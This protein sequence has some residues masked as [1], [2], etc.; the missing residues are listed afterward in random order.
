M[1][2]EARKRGLPGELPVMAGLVESGLKNL[3]HGDADSL[4]L[5]Q[6][7]VSIW[8]RGEYAGFAKDPKLQL[9][10]FL[11]HAETV[12]A[13]RVARGL[14]IDRGSY[15]EWVADV[16]RPAE[17][18]RGRYQERLDEARQLLAAASERPAG[19]ASSAGGA[20]PKALL[21]VAEARKQLGTPYRWGGESKATGFDCSGLMQWAYARAGI[22]L[23]RVADQQ[24][25]AGG[26][27]AVDR[28]HLEPGDLVFFKDPSGYVH[29]VGMSLGGDRFVHAP[30]S[31]DVVK[32]S[33]LDER[34][35]A[36][37]FA[38]GRRFDVAKA[39]SSSNEVQFMRAVPAGAVHR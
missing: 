21:A 9:D 4:G 34:Y 32:I 26:G 13:Q 15:G 25:T 36:G 12:K 8:D 28:R 22:V 10:W 35:Y 31:G 30:S 39:G 33:S 14:P 2:A 11:D 3:G 27:T 29:H 23:P 19:G 18:F 38:G 1:A 16:E 6:M 7:R 24:M 17:Q 5:F 20:G 37:Q